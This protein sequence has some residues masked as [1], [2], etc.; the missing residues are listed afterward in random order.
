VTKRKVGKSTLVQSGWLPS[1]FVIKD[2]YLLRGRVGTVQ[3]WVCDGDDG[4]GRVSQGGGA[5]LQ[6]TPKVIF[7]LFDEGLDDKG[8]RTPRSRAMLGLQTPGL[9]PELKK[10]LKRSRCGEENLADEFAKAD[11]S[12]DGRKRNARKNLDAKVCAVCG[13]CQRREF[14]S[15]RTRANAVDR[16]RECQ[17]GCAE[18][19]SFTDW[20]DRSGRCSVDLA[21][22][23]VSVRVGALLGDPRAARGF[24]RALRPATVELQ[25]LR[26]DFDPM[27]G[28]LVTEQPFSPDA[29]VDLSLTEYADDTEKLFMDLDSLIEAVGALEL[30]SSADMRMALGAL[31][32]SFLAPLD[33]DAIQEPLD[34]GRG[35]DAE[36]RSRA[37]EKKEAK[38]AKKVDG[39][40]EMVEAQ[41]L[42]ESSPE[43]LAFKV[44]FERT[45]EALAFSTGARYGA[46][47]LGATVVARAAAPSCG[48]CSPQLACPVPSA[49][50]CPA[51][52]CAGAGGHVVEPSCLGL[53]TAYAVA[54]LTVGLAVGAVGGAWAARRL[55]GH[56]AHQPPA[57]V[58]IVDGI[59]IAALAAQQ[60]LVLG[61]N[62]GLAYIL[63]PGFD[64]Y[65]EPIVVGPDVRAVLQLAGQGDTPPALA[66]VAVHRF[67]RLPTAAE[68]W[69]AVARSA[70][71]GYPRPADPLPLALAAGNVAGAPA[72]PPAG[73]AAP[74]AMP[75]AAAA[76]AAAPLGVAP[77]VAA[78][79]AALG[80]A[81]PGPVG[82]LPLVPAPAVE[83]AP[84][85]A[86]PAAPAPV[87][88]CRV[89]P[90]QLNPMQLNP[91]FGETVNALSETPVQGWPAQG[92]RAI[93]WCSSFMSTM[94]G[95]PT[96][97]RQRWPTSMALPDEDEYA[98]PRET[99]CRVLDLAVVCDQLQI[100]E[101]ASFE[102]VARQLQLLEER[103]C[104][105]RSAPQSGAAPKAKAAARGGASAGTPSSP[106]TSYFLGA[107]VSKANLCI[108]PKLLEYI[109]DQMM[110]EAAISKE[111][112]KA[113]E[114]L[115]LRAPWRLRT[116]GLAVGR[117]TVA[118]ARCEAALA[119]LL[120][121]A[122]GYSGESR[123]RP[124]NKELVSWP[125]QM[126]PV[127]TADLV[128]A[129][130]LEWE[131]ADRQATFSIGFFFVEKSNGVNLRLVFDTRPFVSVMPMG[132]SW[133]L[134]FCQSAL[135][136]A[137][138]DSGIDESSMLVGGAAIPPLRKD[139]DVIGAG[140]VDNFA[141]VS[142]DPE[143]ATT[144]CQAMR[145]VLVSR[146]LP[147]D[148]FAP[149]AK[150]VVFTGLD[151][152]GDVGIV[153]CKIDRLCRL[154]QAL[155]GLLRRGF[156]SPLALSAV[157][158]HCT[159]G[160]ITNRPMLSIFHSV[161]RFMGLDSRVAAPLWPSVIAE[162]RAAAALIPL[163]WA[164]VRAEWSATTFCSDA[165]PCGVGVCRKAVDQE[166]AAAAG[167][168]SERW[169][170]RFSDAVHARARAL[171]IEQRTTTLAEQ[172][173]RAHPGPV[174]LARVALSEL[175]TAA[176]SDTTMANYWDA[177]KKFEERCRWASQ[178]FATTEEVGVILV[179]YFVNLFLDGFDSATGRVLMPALKHYLPAILAGRLMF[180]TYLRPS[181]AHRLTAG[182]VIRPRPVHDEGPTDGLWTFAPDAVRSMFRRAAAALGLEI[183]LI[184]YSLRHG[185]AS[186]DL[187]SLRRTT[188][189]V[190]D[191]GRWRTDQIPLRFAK[192]ARMQQRIASLGQIIV[193]FNEQ[194]DWQM[195]DLILQT[196]ASG[197]FPRLAP[198]AAG[199]Y[200]KQMG[201][202][203]VHLD[204]SRHA[205][206]D[207][208]DPAVMRRVL[209]WIRSN[210][211][212]CVWVEPDTATCFRHSPAARS[213][214]HPRGLPTLT[215][216]KARSV[217]IA[218]LFQDQYL[219]VLPE[220]CGKK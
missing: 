30:A 210:C 45:S 58:E 89:L 44:L 40:G 87:G 101:M 93:L 103:A 32:R 25:A 182:S 193:E 167:R 129:G 102:I 208:T 75:P 118:P 203:V 181:E 137:I 31:L 11:M 78:L 104:E 213:K 39:G 60:H 175:E 59:D 200:E 192:R 143:V 29:R 20:G 63:T 9:H 81:P 112:R 113:R 91:R 117:A 7:V 33:A 123:V 122:P 216:F 51:C 144:A 160:M 215:N 43:A 56:L 211:I 13:E 74:L 28:A 94:A 106:E 135:T 17:R 36:S 207:I 27:A 168:L 90:M 79:A 68:L 97:W 92:P 209:G 165:S 115:A 8:A 184:L 176:A 120:A 54:A 220:C 189:E 23:F 71:A 134:H 158:G 183:E 178:T 73:A 128:S 72:A 52:V 125:K 12:S 121:S 161:Y 145:D 205:G 18:L 4:A 83:A 6:K 15:D 214:L 53:V 24:C 166:V 108:S 177:A 84:P 110:A 85:A 77:V 35:D 82:A 111:R 26:L 14:F 55:L 141:T 70:A 100:A 140:Y 150:S 163:W 202:G 1:P 114:E 191:R 164:D 65:D 19:G 147:V 98:K 62:G 88:D 151:I 124:Y 171:G 34:A 42:V 132:W 76:A 37:E 201:F 64:D 133:A 199:F 127:P 57:V 66:G 146:G 212:S 2:K 186:D 67:R 69:A 154:R 198:L 173:T 99:L 157:V 95:T 195:N 131:V 5:I 174:L 3:S 187:L 80:A 204:T 38:R 218:N 119:E 206:D 152:L 217:C 21:I 86:A 116:S 179:T 155:L 126:A 180:D 148:E 139:S 196:T 162:L 188:N 149:A 172:R 47:A 16:D 156:A 22:D 138:L 185:G 46:Q 109:A 41:F 194:V 170:Y 159:W 190:K 96:A 48:A 142:L 169:R 219:H 105:T 136:A 197:V 49:F 153:R 130:M 107:G 50:S 10:H 61:V